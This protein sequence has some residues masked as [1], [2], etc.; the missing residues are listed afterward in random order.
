MKCDQDL[1]LNLW[2]DLQK[3][4][5]QDERNPRVRCA[6]GNVWAIIMHPV[7]FLVHS[8]S[9]GTKPL[10]AVRRGDR[11]EGWRG[12]LRI[13]CRRECCAWQWLP[14]LGGY[15]WHDSFV[16]SFYLR[17]VQKKFTL[18]IKLSTGGLLN[19]HDME[20]PW[21]HCGGPMVNVRSNHWPIFLLWNVPL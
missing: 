11:S 16:F 8:A 4:L 10:F 7:V 17:I 21:W 18:M 13:L 15:Y 20:L 12:Q 14:V 9:I 5:W 6:F 1:C 19:Q 3:L 2:Y